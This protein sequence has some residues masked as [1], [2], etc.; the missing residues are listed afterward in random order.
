MSFIGI[1]TRDENMS[2]L[3][4]SNGCQTALGFEPTQIMSKQVKDFVADTY[5][6]SDFM[7][8]YKQRVTHD[9]VLEDEDDASVYCWFTNLKS[10][11]GAPVLHKLISMK[12]D[13]AVIFIG[14]V[15]QG[16][17][18]N[19]LLTQLEVQQID[20][21]GATRSLNVTQRMRDA[22]R[23]HARPLYR[24]HNGQIKA[25]F[26]L[27]NH[28]TLAERNPS[29]D[30]RVTGPL[31]AFCTNVARL[32]EADTSDLISYPFLKLVA[33]ED[34][35]HVTKF[36]ERLVDST[37]VMFERLSLLQ[38]PHVI[39]GDIVVRDEDNFRVVV[40]CMGAAVKDGVVLLLRKLHV[41]PPP[42]RDSLGCFVRASIA[43]DHEND[44]ND[45]GGLSLFDL[46]SDNPDTS[47]APDCWTLIE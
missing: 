39:D 7:G 42:K 40:E 5:R 9:G 44:E 31:I 28:N 17:V 46:L 3:Y 30:Y 22:Q 4:V 19:H 38:R 27:E 2:V 43:Q 12:T 13:T 41:S 11:G 6:A 23:K 36:F 24:T 33:P 15:C 45:I 14:M 16:S 47:D 18:P 32:V 37:D 1:H 35:V 29:P 8:I 10:V 25:A 26:I 34:I 20:A 21:L